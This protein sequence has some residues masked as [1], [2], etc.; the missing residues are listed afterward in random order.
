MKMSI[1]SLTIF[2]SYSAKHSY[3][4]NTLKNLWGTYTRI[5]RIL[6]GRGSLVIGKEEYKIEKNDCIFISP[7]KNAS[8]TMEQENLALDFLMDRNVFPEINL[9]MQSQI[10][11]VIKNDEY[12]CGLTNSMESEY[13]HQLS[14]HENYLH[15]LSAKLLIHLY[16][17]YSRKNTQS[18]AASESAKYR[19]AQKSLDYIASFCSTGISASDVSDAMGVSNEYLDRCFRESVGT[20]PTKVI[21]TV[22]C[23]KATEML[24]RGIYSVTEVALRNGYHSVEHFIREY[25]KYA[26]H[27]PGQAKKSAKYRQKNST[28]DK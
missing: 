27:T 7:C 17:N 13:N 9:Y 14:Y 11:P 5:I 15:S 25:K 2:K 26:C 23:R 19:I 21:N 20:T 22:R 1:D 8:L 4:E 3:P 18:T 28:E 10:S 24:D 12:L 16:R 6:Y